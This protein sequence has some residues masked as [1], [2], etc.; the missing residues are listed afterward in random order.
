MKKNLSLQLSF[1][2]VSAVA[3]VVALVVMGYLLV[4][5]EKPEVLVVGARLSKTLMPGSKGSELSFQLGMRLVESKQFPEAKKV[6]E[7]LLATDAQNVSV[8]NN[9][10]YLL[11]ELGNY[12]SAS[13]YLQT[14]IQVAPDCSECFNNLG[15]I[16]QRQGKTKEAVEQYTK[17]A[18]LDPN[19]PDPRLNLA[20]LYE[21]SGDWAAALDWYKQAESRVQD[22]KH[23]KWVTLRAL[24]MSELTANGGKTRK[25]AGEK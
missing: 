19:H 7:D 14:A 10:A 16:L 6:F 12:P 18:A 23:R 1:L 9:L 25:I 17:A 8:L 15:T 4:R 2:I 3:C 21:E 5:T 22:P 11:G 24:W 20:V 13:Q